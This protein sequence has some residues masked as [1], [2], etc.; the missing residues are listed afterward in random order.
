[1][2]RHDLLALTDD[3]LVQLANAGLVKRGL[4]DVAEGTGPAL[5]ES[6]DGAIEARFA[7]GVVTRLGPEQAVG[8]ASCSC[9]A[10]G[11]CRHRVALV[12]TYRHA[13]R[14]QDAAAPAAW[15]PGTLDLVALEE[16]LTGPART[17]LARLRAAPLIVRLSRGAT[18]V[19]DLPMATVRF[20]APKDAAYARCDCAA[21]HGC[22]HIVL[23][24]EAFRTAGSASE[25][26]LGTAAPVVTSQS[27]R[28]A[29]DAVLARL[30]A[31]GT[32]AG[33]A[34]HAPLIDRAQAMAKAQGATWLVLALE[35]LA[36]QISAYEQRSALYDEAEVLALA[37]EIHARPRASAGSAMG[38]G[39]AMETA[40]A[41]TRLISLG[42]RIVAQGAELAARVA[43][44]DSDTGTPMLVE[45][46]YAAAV[47][48]IRLTPE[49]VLPRPLVPGLPVKGVARGQILT[50][51]ASR[52][53]DG[54]VIFG[55]GARGKTT[56]MPRAVATT[57]PAPLLVTDVAALCEK[58]ASQHPVFLR[59]RNRVATFHVFAV[60]EVLGQHFE[61]GAQLWRAAV[62]LPNDGGRLLLHRRYDA[63][64]PGAIDLMTAAVSGAH[65]P[66]RQLAG[67][68]WMEHGELVCDPW[69]LSADT[70]IVPDVDGSTTAQAAPAVSPSDTATGP[71]AAARFLAGALH[72]GGS[73]RETAFV[74]QGLRLAGELE[75]GGFAATAHRMRHWLG[76]PLHDHIAFGAFAVWLA[77]LMEY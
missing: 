65:G 32:T 77:A 26:T 34:A 62:T 59:A 35:A 52:R 3:G 11:I 10:S 40:M 53:A 75:S 6:P 69:S 64:A 30:L 38:F 9:P 47:P 67:Q 37:T 15:D 43:L 56:L 36:A 7:D 49:Q 39:E 27:L 13:N 68:V 76:A 21:G 46:I 5:T 54:T 72:A 22:A 44:F 25:A 74:K 31:E 66:L 2:A 58:I 71:H 19:A 51:V 55:S 42:A 70:L 4:R 50:S 16:G 24:V 23:A 48:E 8:Q 17:E 41:K 60:D 61:P 45:K 1:M 12:L 63:G 14:L 29:T 73:R 28:D 18:P 33:L 57:P 20:L